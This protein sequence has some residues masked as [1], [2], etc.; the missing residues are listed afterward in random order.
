MVVT[1]ARKTRCIIA[2]LLV[3]R[4]LSRLDLG[5]ASARFS[6]GLSFLQHGVIA[7]ASAAVMAITKSAIAPRPSR[8]VDYKANAQS[9]VL[10]AFMEVSKG[11][12][13]RLL[14]SQVQVLSEYPTTHD[15]ARC[16]WRFRRCSCPD[17][18]PPQRGRAK[19]QHFSFAQ[20]K[21][22]SL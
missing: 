19:I 8:A 20:Q 9:P 6:G 17:A 22:M 18:P 4:S 11:R 5:G 3:P 12:G 15:P 2:F 14:S 16:Q 21:D 1:T 7:T 13:S 10:S